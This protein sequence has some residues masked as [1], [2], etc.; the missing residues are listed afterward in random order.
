MKIPKKLK[1]GGQL[2]D[3]IIRNQRK[4]NGD[5]RLGCSDI[6]ANRIFI[7]RQEAQSSTQ[8][9]STFIHEIIEVISLFNELKFTHEQISCLE[10]SLYQVL[11]DNKLI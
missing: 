5:M 6:Y 8:E 2:F 3:I 4:D 1:I 10:T 11:K 7:N 9:E